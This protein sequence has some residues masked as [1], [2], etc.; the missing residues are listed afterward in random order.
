MMKSPFCRY[1]AVCDQIQILNIE[2]VPS[3]Y[4][5]FRQYICS[6]LPN[7]PRKDEWIA[8]YF[9]NDL[10]EYEK[11]IQYHSVNGRYTDIR[12]II[13]AATSCLLRKYFQ[14]KL[15]SLEQK[16]PLPG[17]RIRIVSTLSRGPKNKPFTEL[18]EE[19]PE[20]GCLW[21]AHYH[22]LE[23]FQSL[24][25]ITITQ[26]IEELSEIVGP[27]HT[28]M[29][30]AERNELN[31][32]SEDD[33]WQEQEFN[34]IDLDSEINSSI[35]SSETESVDDEIFKVAIDFDSMFDEELS[36][37]LQ[38]TNQSTHVEDM[39]NEN[40]IRSQ[41]IDDFS[42][43]S[44]SQERN[45]YNGTIDSSSQERENI[46]AQEREKLVSQERR[47]SSQEKVSPQVSQEKKKCLLEKE[48]ENLQNT[49]GTET[50]ETEDCSVES[51]VTEEKN[52]KER[53][54][55]RKKDPICEPSK[56]RKSTRKIQWF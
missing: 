3:T 34:V 5:A 55:K 45:N 4:D 12:G 10:G 44:S 20:N 19:F 13:C 28:E 37:K 15:M 40:L 46:V 24:E 25:K 52:V 38:S 26:P 11:F 47:T 16:C 56:V 36:R 51:N 54:R 22:T 50:E 14:L 53:S 31:N 29:S 43:R 8:A 6:S 33:E 35:N 23:H 27:R 30:V 18:G 21:I 7:I 32:H 49:K 39:E 2:G 48:M 42:M 17:R 41:E 1:D 9:N